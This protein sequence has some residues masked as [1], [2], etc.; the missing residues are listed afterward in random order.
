MKDRNHIS[1][2]ICLLIIGMAIFS[3]KSEDKSDPAAFFMPGEFEPHEAVWFGTWYMSE[4]A[5]DY[6]RVMS[7]VMKAIDGHVQ[8]K[9]A[10]P[11]DSVLQIAKRQLDSLG[12]DT[13]KI[14]FH[15]M[16][17]EAHWIRDHGASFVV[18]RQGELGAVDF[19][20]NG[21]GSLDWRILRDSTI[22][23]SV[24]VFRQKTRT[25]DRAK[26][27]SLMAGATHAKWIKGNL[28]IEGGAIEVNGKGVLIQCEAVTLQRNPG[29]TKEALEEEYK[30][31]LGIK[32]VIW[33]PEGLAE[34]GHI[35]HFNLG[36]Y[37][38]IGTGGHT[39]EFVRFA[40]A[41]T[42]LLA[43]V[44]ES[45]LDEHPYNKLNYERMSKSYEIL[46]KATDQDGKP[47]KIIKIPMPYYQEK[48]VVV[49]DS[50]S[51]DDHIRVKDFSYADRHLIKVGDTLT[52]V[53]ASSYMNF[54]VTNGVVVTA[55]YAKDEAS[56]KRE[57]EVEVLFKKAFPGRKIV[58]VDAMRLNWGG[59]GIHCSTQ[60]EPLK[61]SK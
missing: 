58:F 61:R 24:A 16:P 18:N 46:K 6:K 11:S 40:D 28:T 43:W 33:L 21:Y 2:L 27:D 19:E 48:P 54:L 37:I 20:W 13:A 35:A 8:I 60:Q 47:F 4:W 49:S 59:G 26:V 25:S 32:K 23:D 10:S 7:E 17:G 34:D 41:R 5:S 1:V 12:V 30:R 57:K 39:D 53:A 9:M 50:L 42:I 44:N 29:W 31:T 55:S 52:H 51:N 36:K 3:C 56:I 14:E 22:L 45:E 38:G 15:I